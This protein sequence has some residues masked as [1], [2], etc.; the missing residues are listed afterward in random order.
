MG[1][2][3]SVKVLLEEQGRREEGP[4]GVE[5][6][7]RGSLES[8]VTCQGWG[9]MCGQVSARGKAWIITLVVCQLLPFVPSPTSSQW[10]KACLT[11]FK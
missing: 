11:M 6:V 8:S 5:E 1:R 4:P 9:P 3:E 7:G 10:S 2:R